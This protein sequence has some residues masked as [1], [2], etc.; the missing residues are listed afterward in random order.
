MT[1]RIPNT[2]GT[3]TKDF[4]LKNLHKYR[5]RRDIC[6]CLLQL[7]VQYLLST[8]KYFV[9]Q[10]LVES[11]MD[12]LSGDSLIPYRTIRDS[13]ILLLV[14]AVYIFLLVLMITLLFSWLIPTIL[15]F[16]NP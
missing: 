15:T 3:N 5:T 11:G 6:N 2:K 12:G 4:L 16:L 8:R 9:P 7:E 1:K 13:L 14:A 10:I